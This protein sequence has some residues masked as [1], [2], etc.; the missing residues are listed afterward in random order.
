MQKKQNMNSIR[1]HFVS[2]EHL[3]LLM[4]DAEFQ[5]QIE[6]LNPVRFEN[7]YLDLTD[8]VE[9]HNVLDS[10]VVI[11]A[12]FARG[13]KRILYPETQTQIEFLNPIVNRPKNGLRHDNLII[14]DQCRF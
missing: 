5:S 4:N 3:N 14:I 10:E 7:N 12:I 9:Q 6:Y 13:I 8:T 11:L 1:L 2:R